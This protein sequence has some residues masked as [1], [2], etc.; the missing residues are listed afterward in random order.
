MSPIVLYTP[1]SPTLL[2]PH[3][4][5]P[6]EIFWTCLA[7]KNPSPRIVFIH[8]ALIIAAPITT[9]S[10]N[11]QFPSAVFPPFASPLCKVPIFSSP[12]VSNHKTFLF[13]NLHRSSF[14]LHHFPRQP[15]SGLNFF[16]REQEPP[17]QGSDWE[18]N[19]A[20]SKFKSIDSHIFQP[21]FC[22]HL[23]DKAFEFW[24]RSLL[25]CWQLWSRDYH[26]HSKLKSPPNPLECPEVR[27]TT[28]QMSTTHHHPFAAIFQISLIGNI[29]PKICPKV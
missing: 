12:G 6:S 5:I 27:Q 3:P 14:R 19:Y 28:W 24:P 25:G 23:G 1:P 8:T 10:H 29:S 16:G 26:S 4:K 18:A 11:T 22:R 13:S 2:H 9:T 17:S 15:N 7:G 21:T 20:F